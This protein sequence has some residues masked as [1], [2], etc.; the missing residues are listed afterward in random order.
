M[1]G[2]VQISVVLFFDFFYNINVFFNILKIKEPHVLVFLSVHNHDSNLFF[3]ILW[4]SQN[5]EHPKAYLALIGDNFVKN[6]K[7]ANPQKLH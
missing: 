5:G 1:L 6:L 2:V 3:P 4:W 7:C